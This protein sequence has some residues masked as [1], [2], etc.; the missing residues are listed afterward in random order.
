MTGHPDEPAEPFSRAAA[1]D[2]T[3]P[4]ARTPPPTPR[5]PPGCV[6]GPDR[7]GRRPFASTSPPTRRGPPGRCARR[8]WSQGT[9]GRGWSPTMARAAA[10]SRRSPCRVDVVDPVCVDQGERRIGAILV[11]RPEGCRPEDHAAGVVSG[12]TEGL[13]GQHERRLLTWR[14]NGPAGPASGSCPAP[15]SARLGGDLDHLRHLVAGDQSRQCALNTSLL[16]S[17]PG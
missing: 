2:S 10:Q 9:P 15:T 6:A 7:R 16:R 1:S 8:S 17:A 5:A 3:A 11:H 4:P 14:C 12:M 13:C